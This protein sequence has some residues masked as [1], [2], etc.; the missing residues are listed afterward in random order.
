MTSLSPAHQ[1]QVSTPNGFG[2]SGLAASREVSVNSYESLDAGLTIQTRE[3]DVVSLSTSSFTEMNA[4]EYTARGKFSDENGRVSAAYNVREITLSSGETF[5]FSVRGDLNE[6]ELA[7]IESIVA[8]IDEIIGE[9]VEGDMDDAVAKALSMGSFD[10]I[11]AY[12][13]DI[14]VQ[15][16]YSV[17]Q[18]TR[19]S[20]YSNRPQL[21]Q[22]GGGVSAPAD[23]GQSYLEQLKAL[24]EARE[25]ESVA[26][27]RQPLR[28]LF[29]HHLNA[30]GAPEKGE[31]A[32]ET[33]PASPYKTLEAV[34]RQVDEMINDMVKDIFEN[35]LDQLV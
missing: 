32:Y 1:G 7:D 14:S 33:S 20:A 15:R 9:V 12:E 26:R 8:G 21:D 6:Q 10:S 31:D 19:S 27:A 34:A 17:Y 35:T 18:E 4:Y 29:D 23:A 28:Q 16:S 22:A 2:R 11:S 24:L 30:L 3:G 25:E 13:A 5:S